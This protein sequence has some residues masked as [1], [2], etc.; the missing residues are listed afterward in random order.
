[1]I[2]KDEKSLWL[3]IRVPEP[4]AI[5]PF[6]TV[7]IILAFLNPKQTLYTSNQINARH[8]DILKH[9]SVTLLSKKDLLDNKNI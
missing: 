9:I 6:I 8:A 7:G 4:E 2:S 5:G 3:I 1:M